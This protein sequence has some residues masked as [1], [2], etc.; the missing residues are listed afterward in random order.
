MVRPSLRRTSRFGVRTCRFRHETSEKPWSSVKIKMIFGLSGFV[1]AHCAAPSKTFQLQDRYS[2]LTQLVTRKFWA[3][4][5]LTLDWPWPDPSQSMP[6]KSFI[7]LEKS[8]S[9][10]R[11]CGNGTLKIQLTFNF[12]VIESYE[13]WN[14]LILIGPPSAKP[15]RTKTFG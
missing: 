11:N 6:G 2:A 7:S 4:I 13:L 14:I 3:K 1:L 15:F 8:F 5:T 9:S 12:Y 10:N